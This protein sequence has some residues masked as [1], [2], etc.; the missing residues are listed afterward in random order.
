MNWL[1]ALI[2][3]LI[4]G[5]TEFLPVSSSGHLEIGKALLGIEAGETLMFTVVVHGATVL[6]TIFVF[7]KD[8]WT[9]FSDSLSLKWNDSTRYN[10]KL[11]ISMV[12]VVI[13]GLFF[14]EEIEQFFTGRV[15]FV[16]TMLLITAALLASTYLRKSN[17]REIGYLDGLV[18]GL[19][20]AIAVLPGI[21]RS[22]ATISMGLLLGNKREEVTRFSFLMVLVPIIGANAKDILDTGFAGMERI[23]FMPLAVGFVA[24]F[25]SGLLACKAMISIVKKGGLLWFAL[26]CAVLGIV[27]IVLG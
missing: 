13:L 16:G 4:Q 8:L 15:V 20:Q 5:L 27:A 24:A 11:L 25:L 12:P 23:G 18:I 6:S 21:S 17:K 22:G 19:A 3:G 7:R 14:K 9:L 1:E 26:Y 2:L 10:L